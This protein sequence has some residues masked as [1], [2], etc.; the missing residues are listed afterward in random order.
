ML[1]RICRGRSGQ[2]E[3]DIYSNQEGKDGVRSRE[4]V[5]DPNDAA[6]I[7]LVD[8]YPK[9]TGGFTNTFRYYFADLSFNFS[10][11]LGGHSYDAAMWAL[12]DDGHAAN[13]K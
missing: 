12:Q 11:S 1:E 6:S 5:Y 2:R 8:I 13:T 9:L 10:F 7:P 3:T 4:K